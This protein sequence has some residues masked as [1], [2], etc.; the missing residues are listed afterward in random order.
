[1]FFLYAAY[2][3]VTNPRLEK[4]GVNIFPFGGLSFFAS[5]IKSKLSVI[6]NITVPSRYSGYESESSRLR[7][8]SQGIYCFHSVSQKES[9]SGHC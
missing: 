2:L 8:R 7:E 9:E 3:C 4:K 6:T 5:I 1:M